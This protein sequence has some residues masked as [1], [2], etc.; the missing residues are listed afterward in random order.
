MLL[1]IL[2]DSMGC[3]DGNSITCGDMIAEHGSW[4][5]HISYMTG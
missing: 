2:K 3:A 4:V 1:T 5:L